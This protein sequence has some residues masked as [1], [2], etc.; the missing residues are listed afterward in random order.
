MSDPYGESRQ[1]QQPLY[2]NQQNAPEGPHAQS[3]AQGQSQVQGRLVQD[4][5]SAQMPPLGQF[6]Q[7]SD[8]SQFYSHTL[9][10]RQ[11]PS[12]PPMRTASQAGV[13]SGSMY[14]PP[15]GLQ[16]IPSLSASISSSLASSVGPSGSSSAQ[17]PSSGGKVF[18]CTDYPGCSMSFSRSEHLARHIRKH[19]GETTPLYFDCR[20][21]PT[22]NAHCACRGKAFCVSVR[23]EFYSIRQS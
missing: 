22:S 21:C 3:Q 9:L 2:T 12:L 18:Q 6:G 17:K 13:P 4:S 8:Q 1:P 7:S 20:F 10:P 16:P 19:T 15:V 23:Q 11:I 14:G 5:L